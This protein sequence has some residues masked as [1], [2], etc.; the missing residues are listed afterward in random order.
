MWNRSKPARMSR[1]RNLG[2]VKRKSI[3]WRSEPHSAR[4]TTFWPRPRKFRSVMPRFS[5]KE[6]TELKPAPTDSSPVG[7]SSTVTLTTLRSGALPRVSS[8]LTSLKKPRPRRLL[9]ERSTS[10]RLKASP[11]P[12]INS[13]R[14]TESRVRVLPTT[15]IRSM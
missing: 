5:T 8:I 12:T 10:A 14:I 2:S 13:R 4:A 1:P 6:S 3:C 15:L 11:S 7:C 9:R